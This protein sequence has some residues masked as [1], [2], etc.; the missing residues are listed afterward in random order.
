LNGVDCRRCHLC[1][2]GELKRRRKAKDATIREARM[3][4]ALGGFASCG[5]VAPKSTTVADLVEVEPAT[6]GPL[7]PAPPQSVRA[8]STRPSI[9]CLAPPSTPPGVFLPSTEAALHSAV[10]AMSAS[11]S[12]GAAPREADHGMPLQ[13]CA[14]PQPVAPGSWVPPQEWTRLSVLAPGPRARADTAERPPPSPPLPRGPE[15]PATPAPPTPRVPEPSAG[16]SLH[17]AGLCQPCTWF[18]KPQGCLN[19]RECNRCHLCPEGEVR[20]R[21]KA[22]AAARMLDQRHDGIS[23]LGEGMEVIPRAPSD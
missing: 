10:V 23:K 18:W 6:V 8:P 21:K 16:A 9:F 2:E 14:R 4:E 13:R 20:R 3:Q 17:G 1:P 11:R 15:Q 5:S 19:G 7:P 12:A 22:K